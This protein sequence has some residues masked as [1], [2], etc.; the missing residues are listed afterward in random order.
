MIQCTCFACAYKLP[1]VEDRVTKCNMDFLTASAEHFIILVSLCMLA[2]A[3]LLALTVDK[4]ASRHYVQEWVRADG[5]FTC[6]LPL[7]QC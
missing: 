4:S 5:V 1:V 6:A 3:S 2:I 7:Q